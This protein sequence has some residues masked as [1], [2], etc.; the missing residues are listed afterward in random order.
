MR[1]KSAVAEART[2]LG[3]ALADKAPAV[4]IAAAEALGR[5]GDGNDVER[6]VA[7][8]AELAPAAGNG[9][10]VSMQALNALGEL[11]PRARPA[12]VAIRGAAKGIDQAPERGRP[13]V[14]RLVDK[15]VADLAAK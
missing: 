7:T 1:G 15:L 3:K 6:A 5:Y 2:E 13:G 9:I 4:R 11:G 8:L 12:L 10:Y 14:E